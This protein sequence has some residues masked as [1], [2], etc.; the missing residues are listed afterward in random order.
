MFK[1]G[2]LAILCVLYLQSTA[3]VFSDKTTSRNNADT[4]KEHKF[5]LPIWGDKAIAAGYNLPY[6]GGIGINYLWQQS[7][8]TINNLEVG[9]NNGTKYNMDNIVQFNNATS[10]SNGFNIRPDV[11]ILP[12]LNVYGIIAQSYSSTAVDVDL[13]VP[14]DPGVPGSAWQSVANFQT[15]AEFQGTTAGFG[16]TP[17]MGIKGAWLAMDMNFT[18]TDI[19]QLD[20]PAFAFVFGPRLGKSFKLKKPDRSFAIWTGGFRINLASQ[21][22]GSIALG[23]LFDTDGLGDKINSGLLKVGDAQQSVDTWWSGLSPMEQNN[24]INIK[25]KSVADEALTKAE[26]VL[27][28]MAGAVANAENSSV[29]YSLEKKQTQLWNFLIGGQFQYNKHWMIRA[30]CGFLGTR[31]QIIAGLQYRFGI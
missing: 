31:T 5:L 6:S 16:I 11:W 25:K 22:S 29:Q 1:N 24:P 26:L 21:T 14:T 20:K 4:L 8:I 3:Q 18:W 7:D 13:R 9:F 17:T 15:K 10:T 2:L 19:P 27:N 12:F 23:D 28:D 30:E